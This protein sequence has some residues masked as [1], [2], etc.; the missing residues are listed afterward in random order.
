MSNWGCPHLLDGKCERV[1]QQPCELGMKGCVLFGR[2]RFADDSK[3]RP[4]K[5]PAT[6][7]PPQSA[8]SDPT[9]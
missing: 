3:N 2:F 9:E 1:N 4:K 8:D 5:T 6:P 7:P